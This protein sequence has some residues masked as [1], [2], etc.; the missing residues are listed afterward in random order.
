MFSTLIAFVSH[1]NQLYQMK[2]IHNQNQIAQF[3]FLFPY[4]LFLIYVPISILN[5]QKSVEMV[6]VSMFFG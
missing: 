3:V 6:L 2:L 5:I 4:M 1:S